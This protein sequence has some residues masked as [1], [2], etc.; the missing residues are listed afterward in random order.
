VP[1][2]TPIR[3][4]SIV[5]GGSHVFFPNGALPNAEWFGEKVKRSYLRSATSV[6]VRIRSFDGEA[7]CR[8]LPDALYADVFVV[9]PEV[10]EFDQLSG[11]KSIGALKELLGKP[12]N[13]ISPWEHGTA[14]L[15]WRFCNGSI[16]RYFKAFDVTAVVRPPEEGNISGKAADW[17]IVVI[18]ARESIP[19]AD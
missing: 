8:S 14:C 10:E 11:L 1:G 5:F 2:V 13:A 9:R 7:L 19:S 16:G 3:K 12:E 15:Q 4:T 6:D 17:W 18:I